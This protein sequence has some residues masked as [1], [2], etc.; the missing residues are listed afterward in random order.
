MQLTN[1]RVRLM[2]TVI[3]V[4]IYHKEPEPLLDQVE[5]LLHTYNK[6][7]SANDDSSELMKIN[8]AAGLH[9]VT[10]HPELLNLFLLENGIA[11]NL[12]VTLI[13]LLGL[14]FQTWRI[15]FL[16]LSCLFLKKFVRSWISSIPMP[17]FYP[18]KIKAFFSKKR[19]EN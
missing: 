12:E 15:G 18:R 2:G 17:F 7:F 1:R 14:S 8:K 5:A 13:L 19:D 9:P 3:D 16:M 4:S 11:A 6:R 10:V